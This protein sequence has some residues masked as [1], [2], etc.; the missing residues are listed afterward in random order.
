LSFLVESALERD[1][2]WAGIRA[3][4]GG[5]TQYLQIT[6]TPLDL[7]AWTGAGRGCSLWTESSRLHA[8]F[9]LHLIASFCFA[10]TGMGDKIFLPRAIYRKLGA[11]HSPIFLSAPARSSVNC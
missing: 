6:S 2:S 3:A 4:A 9:H 7:V 5:C 1:S 11:L 8:V 10:S